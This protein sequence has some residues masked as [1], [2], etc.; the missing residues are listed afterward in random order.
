MINERG[1]GASSSHAALRVRHVGRSGF[2]RFAALSRLGLRGSGQGRYFL[3]LSR[4]AMW[5]P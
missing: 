3:V 1:C 5:E 4:V 2:L